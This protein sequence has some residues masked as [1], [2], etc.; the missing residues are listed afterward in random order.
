MEDNKKSH[1]GAKKAIDDGAEKAVDKGAEQAINDR[2]KPEITLEY[3]NM[4]ARN[5]MVARNTHEMAKLTLDG[6]PKNEDSR[7]KNNISL[8][9]NGN[10]DCSKIKFDP[11]FIPPPLDIKKRLEQLRSYLDPNDPWYQPEYQHINIRAIIKLYEEGKIDGKQHVYIQ[12]GKIVSREESFKGPA[13][14]AVEGMFHQYAQKAS[15]GHRL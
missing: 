10:I 1:N 5:A 3:L 13:P 14:S 2:D 7:P 4:V 6:K 15:Y 12:D 11:G 8:D 9:E